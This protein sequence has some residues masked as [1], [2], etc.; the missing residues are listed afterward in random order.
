[1]ASYIAAI[2]M[3]VDHFSYMEK[4]TFADNLLTPCHPRCQCLSFFSRKE[5]NV[6]D[7]NIPAFF[8]TFVM[9]FELVHHYEQIFFRVNSFVSFEPNDSGKDLFILMNEFEPLHSLFEQGESQ[10]CIAVHRSL[11]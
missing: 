6:F 2:E 4:K 7:E 8:S 5:I 9:L 10:T 11:I 3:V 1:M